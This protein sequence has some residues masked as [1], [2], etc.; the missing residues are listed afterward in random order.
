MFKEFAQLESVEV[1]SEGHPDYER[2]RRIFNGYIDR[3]PRAILYPETEASLLAVARLALK[4][5]HPFSIRAGGHNVAGSSIVEGGH[6]IDTSRLAGVRV[7]RSRKTADVQ[8]G[9][10]WRDFDSMTA[11]YRLCTPGGIISDTGVAG[12]TLGGGIGWLNGLHG[13]S[14]DNLIEADVMLSSGEVVV[15][16]ESQNFDLLWALRGGGG[17]FGLVTRF[18]FCLHPSPRLF[19]GSIVYNRTDLRE[20]MLRYFECC[21]S[22]PDELT[23]SFVAFCGAGAPRISLDVCYAGGAESGRALT[24]ALLPRNISS[25]I[26]DTRQVYSYVNWQRQFDDD[27]RRGRRSYWRAVYIQDLTAP[28]FL[29]ILARYTASSPS[30]HSMLTV[31]HV[32]GAAHR[33]DRSTS[34]YGDRESKYLFLINTNWDEP[35][36]DYVNLAWCNA[37]F[38]EIISFGSASTYVNYLSQEGEARIKSAFGPNMSRL[39]LVKGLFDPDNRFKSNQNI[40]PA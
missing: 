20:A 31:D 23:M 33:Q 24:D 8:P 21:E 26:R 39:R 27:K 15:A 9:A 3:R 38:D 6:V 16:S 18:R 34:A 25:L 4:L 11:K 5:D 35:K 19:A 1:V 12:L 10:L 14:C 40:V 13:L 32:H 29:E 36:D 28:H 37:L 30:D 22:A 7:D 2:E 17:N